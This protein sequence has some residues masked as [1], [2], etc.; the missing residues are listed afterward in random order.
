MAT[1]CAALACALV[2]AAGCG[3]AR[4]RDYAGEG[5]PRRGGADPSGAAG[6]SSADM[7]PA[8]PPP[9]VESIA[10]A[11]PRVVVRADARAIAVDASHLYYGDA[12][13]D[14]VFA[15]PK[16]GGEP[17]R[18]ARRAP[19]AGALA[20]DGT[21]IAWIASPGD[22]VLRAPVA[23]GAATSLRDRGIFADVVSVGSDVFIAEAI[24]GGGALTR[25][26]G[27]TASKL[28]AFDGAPRC[29]LADEAAAYLVTPTKIFR[30][31][32]T[33]GEVTTVATG[34]GFDSAQLAGEQLYVVMRDGDARV[35]GRV[36]KTGGTMTTIARD[37]RD[38]PIDVEGEQ[39]LY[40]DAAL[41]QL[42]TVRLSGGPPRVLAEDEALL[43][44][45]SLAADR[46][47]AYV[48]TGAREAAAVIA[49]ERRREAPATAP[50]AR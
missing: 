37:V 42:R 34:A 31:P 6:T 9:I 40:F 3:A 16:A 39:L 32:R 35:V 27:A 11:R 28:T 50:R 29:V 2:A 8:A 41:P 43:S 46:T 22:V 44:P 23:G 24:G 14:G 19:V 7:V 21:T 17:V 33:R 48:G 10:P 5:R 36:P 13:E 1:A 18:I 25:V 20:L 26:T 12:A 38:A 30:V 47:T 45:T 49:I 4:S 15:V